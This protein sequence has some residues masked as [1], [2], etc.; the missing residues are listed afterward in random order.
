M[1]EQWG[2]YQPPDEN[3]PLDDPIGADFPDQAGDDPDAD[4]TDHGA[5]DH[6]AD[7]HGTGEHPDHQHHKDPDK[8]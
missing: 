6:G 5:T 3:Q 2:N 7:E 4:T 8:G 1:T